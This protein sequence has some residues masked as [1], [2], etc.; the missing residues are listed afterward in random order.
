ML[1]IAHYAN[2]VRNDYL[3]SPSGL[4]ENVDIIMPYPVDNMYA[5]HREERVWHELCVHHL[6]HLYAFHYSGLSYS[7][8]L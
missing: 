8:K 1:F 4:T 6:T 5:F 3:I 2:D 7:E